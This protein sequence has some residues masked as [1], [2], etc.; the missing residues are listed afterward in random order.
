MRNKLSFYID[1][2]S[3]LHRLNPLTKLAVTFAFIIIAFSA[4]WYWTSAV[5]FVCAIIPIAFAGKIGKEFIRAGINLMLPLFAFLFVM[6]SLFHPGGDT[7]LFHF[8]FLSVKAESISFAFL[9]TMR[10]LVMVSS[11]LLVLL[12]THPSYLMNDLTQRGMP[13]TL[14][15]IVTSTLQIIPQMQNKAGTIVDAQ[16]SRGLNTEGN[17]GQ[18]IKALLPLIGPLVFGSL[19]DVEERAV[20]LEAR[21]FNAARKKTSLH[22]IPDTTWENVL[23]WVCL[24]LVVVSIGSNIWLS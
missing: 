16:R 18:R 6:Q 4:P 2:P 12:S 3:P 17:L 19:V 7:V 1:R 22:E 5:L 21:A 11:F 20:A 15:Y 24:I 23:R 13:S 14:S 9:T 8:W 10:I